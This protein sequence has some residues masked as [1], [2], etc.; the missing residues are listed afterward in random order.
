MSHIQQNGVKLLAHAFQA[1][2]LSKGI[3]PYY[4]FY[5]NHFLTS[6][7]NSLLAT[8]F[9]LSMGVGHGL[10]RLD[11]SFVGMM[12]LFAKGCVIWALLFVAG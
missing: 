1:N 11:V 7:T 4:G 9:K 2:T 10:E 5:Q 6:Q 3:A 8:F 12:P